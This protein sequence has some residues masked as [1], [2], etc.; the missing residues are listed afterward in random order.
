MSMKKGILYIVLSAIFFS[1]M[2]IAIKM[3]A[4]TFHPI[5][6]NLLRFF[7]GAVILSPLAFQHMK[8][9][10]FHMT[11][12]SFLFFVVTGFLCIVISMTFYQL[13]IVYTKASTVAILF[14]CNPLFVI[15]LAHFLLKERLSKRTLVALG[16]S[17]VGILFI[18][19]PFEI[20]SPFGIIVALLSAVTFALY[21]VVGRKGSQQFKCDGVILTC[22]SF[23]TGSIE[24][25]A[26]VLISKIGFVA[27][28]LRSVGLGVFAN[29]PVFRGIAWHTLPSLIYIGIFVT[30]LGFAFYFLAMDVTSASMASMVFFIKPALAPILA[31]IFLREAIT[32]AVTVGIILIV[33]GSL[34]TLL[35]AGS[36]QPEL[37]VSRAKNR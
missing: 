32:P 26:L 6:L 31:L 5:Q 8:K 22:L 15:P 17:L 11:K 28:W 24:I 19:N 30:G 36:K 27:G 7:I 23:F 16:I 9:Y 35:P 14:S 20:Q 2:E 34:M 4:G 1:T 10:H 3:V 25:L 29:V 12:D 18:V 13:A 21:S 33:A 37:R